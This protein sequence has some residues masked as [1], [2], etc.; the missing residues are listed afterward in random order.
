MSIMPTPI[1][2]VIMQTLN[3]SNGGAMM[4][5]LGA[6]CAARPSRVATILRL[7]DS[8]ETRDQSLV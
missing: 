8:R 7:A 3:W 4:G 5:T 6:Q 2:R 1:R